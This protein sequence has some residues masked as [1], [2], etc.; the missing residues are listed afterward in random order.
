MDEVDEDLAKAVLVSADRRDLA[1][2]LDDEVDAL[3]LGE[4]AQTL[5][6]GLRDLVEI[7]VVDERHGATLL[8]PR[9]VEDLVDHLHE[10]PGL[11]ADLADAVLHPRR[12]VRLLGV[13]RER[14]G[15]QAHRRERCPQ[16]VRQV[17][18]EFRADPLEPAQLRDVLHHDPGTAIP[19]AAR[20]DHVRRPIGRAQ[21]HLGACEPAFRRDPRHLVDPPVHERFD[22]RLSDE[23]S[24]SAF[25][26]LVRETV[27]KCDSRVVIEAHER[28]AGEV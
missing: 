2:D 20:A 15:K 11:H 17:F 22:C 7:H 5:G 9:E 14:L 23:R 18:G 25:E 12:H 27:R 1:V 19:R 6:R 10:M 4:H 21:R 28:H 3:A 8:D 24:R 26:V 13:L 16:L